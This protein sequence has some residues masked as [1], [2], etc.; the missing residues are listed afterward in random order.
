M[1]EL[2]FYRFVEFEKRYEKVGTSN[3]TLFNETLHL[4][5]IFSH[6]FYCEFLRFK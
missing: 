6:Q 2:V 4:F 1:C 5:K 3:V